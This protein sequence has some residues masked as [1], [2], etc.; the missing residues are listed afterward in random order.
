[1]FAD[2]E[3]SPFVRSDLR[4]SPLLTA[5]QVSQNDEAA[6]GDKQR[7]GSAMNLREEQALHAV[8]VRLQKQFPDLLPHEIDTLVRGKYRAFDGSPVRDFIPILVERQTREALQ[9]TGTSRA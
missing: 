1:M 8:T 7:A 2:R 3:A 9:R 4:K 6:P 5:G